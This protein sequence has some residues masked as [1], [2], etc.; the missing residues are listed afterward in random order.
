MFINAK[1]VFIYRQLSDLT[2]DHSSEKADLFEYIVY[3]YIS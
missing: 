2:E 3:V 1:R